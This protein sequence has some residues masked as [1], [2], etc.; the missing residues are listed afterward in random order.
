MWGTNLTDRKHAA[1]YIDFGPG[2]GS[3]TPV[4][5]ID[6]RMAGIEFKLRW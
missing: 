6:P 5:Y 3:L 1:N 4:Y 2:F